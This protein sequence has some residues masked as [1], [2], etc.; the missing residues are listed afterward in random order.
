MFTVVGEKNHLQK[1]D[2]RNV[3]LLLLL[4]LMWLLAVL[5]ST[6]CMPDSMYFQC[7]TDTGQLNACLILCTFTVLLTL[8][9][10]MRAWF[11]VLSVSYWHWPAECMPD[12]MYFQCPTDTGQLNAC[13][14]LCTFSVLPTLAKLG[15]TNSLVVNS[16]QVCP[17][18]TITSQFYH[19]GPS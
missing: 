1:N 14:I 12:S 17:M 2:F 18:L 7:P 13:L 10:W 3:L 19:P 15:K 8:A 6:E 16:K 4:L 9:S 5:L 11:Y